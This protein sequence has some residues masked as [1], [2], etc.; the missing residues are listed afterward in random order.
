[1]RY[2]FDRL[3]AGKFKGKRHV[4]D[5]VVVEGTRNANTAAFGETLQTRRYVDPVT[6]NPIPIC[7]DIT[8]LHADTEA[9]APALR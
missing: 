7:N 1:M 2:V 9:H 6:L 8:V 5:V 3:L 4:V